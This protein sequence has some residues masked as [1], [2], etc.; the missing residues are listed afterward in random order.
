MPEEIKKVPA[1]LLL[2]R[3]NRIVYGD[4]ILEIFKPILNKKFSHK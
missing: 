3:G 2:N 4:E 1:L